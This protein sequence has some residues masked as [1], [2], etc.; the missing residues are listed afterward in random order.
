MPSSF[1]IQL[2]GESGD[3]AFRAQCIML[4]YAECKSDPH[5]L[6]SVFQT[7]PSNKHGLF[8]IWGRQWHRQSCPS[9]TFPGLSKA[10]FSC[11]TV[12]KCLG[13]KSYQFFRQSPFDIYPKANEE[14]TRGSSDSHFIS[15]PETIHSQ[16]FGHT[17]V[18]MTVKLFWDGRTSIETQRTVLVLALSAVLLPRRARVSLMRLRMDC[19]LWSAW[20]SV[21]GRDGE[22]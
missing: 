20:N 15:I 13:T 2:F 17:P 10:Q 14:K 8:L 5:V 11:Q 18:K 3:W 21:L 19:H 1:P 22:K 9:N 6:G 4:R 7:E 16:W 12:N